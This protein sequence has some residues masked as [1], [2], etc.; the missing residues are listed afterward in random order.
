M[1]FFYEM[2][3]EKMNKE[4][5][6]YI[7]K[8][9]KILGYK[10]DDDKKSYVIDEEQAKVVKAIIELQTKYSL[11]NN[12]IDLLIK[13]SID[14]DGI[15]AL[16]LDLLYERLEDDLNIKNSLK[17]INVANSLKS[18]NEFKEQL[19]EDLSEIQIQIQIQNIS[20]DDDF[21]KNINEID[22]IKLLLNNRDEIFQKYGDFKSIKNTLIDYIK[23]SNDEIRM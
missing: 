10:Y 5:N 2:R 1:F 17:N 15:I 19:E 23:E 11:N 13:G 9:N 8:Q 12:E 4:N 21:E 6:N 7:A 16:K 20:S 3:K 22:K 14:I 18:V